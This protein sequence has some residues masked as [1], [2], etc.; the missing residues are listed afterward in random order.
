MIDNGI[1]A[2]LMTTKMNEQ[3]EDKEIVRVNSWD[4]IYAEIQKIKKGE[5]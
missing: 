4:E 3:I 1:K 2:I 5:I